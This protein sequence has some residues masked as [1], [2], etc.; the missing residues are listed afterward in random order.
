[1]RFGHCLSAEDLGLTRAHSHSVVQSMVSVLEE[2]GV[3]VHQP[4][5]SGSLGND[6]EE[7]GHPSSLLL[8]HLAV[9]EGKTVKDDHDDG[10]G[11]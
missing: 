4:A 6:P 2:L 7:E 1:M 3:V 11:G 8:R 10:D 9:V 5:P